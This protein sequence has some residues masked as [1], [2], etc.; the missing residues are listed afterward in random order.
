MAKKI[1]R[2]FILMLLSLLTFGKNQEVKAS[3]GGLTEVV[4]KRFPCKVAE[5]DEECCTNNDGHWS[6]DA[7]YA[8]LGSYDPCS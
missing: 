3:E 4:L 2:Y 5:T 6:N 8:S 1:K 7:C